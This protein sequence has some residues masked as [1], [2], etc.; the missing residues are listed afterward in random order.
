VSVELY[1]RAVVD[2]LRVPVDE[3]G[4][5]YTQDTCGMEPDAR[6]PA[7]SG[8]EYVS[9]FAGERRS[10][11]DG[12]LETEV[13]FN[14]ALV[15]R[16]NEPLDRV[17]ES[18]MGAI[19]NGLKARAAKVVADLMKHENLYSVMNNVNDLLDEQAGEPVSGY[20]EPAWFKGDRGPEWVGPDLLEADEEDGY[21]CACRIILMFGPA[22]RVQSL[23]T[24][25]GA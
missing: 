24:P 2:R 7:M 18:T 15:E 25:F 14:V 12:C 5:G 17:G 13:S 23:D 8:K 22:R 6:I 4:L 1:E 21:Y 3:G 19:G 16:V 11:Q 10:T 20:C 9:V